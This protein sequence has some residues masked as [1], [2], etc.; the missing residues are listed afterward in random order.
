MAGMASTAPVIETGVD[1]LIEL[2]ERKKDLSLQE[3]ANLLGV[4]KVVVEEWVSFLEEEGLISVDYKLG[5]TK[6][7]LKEL[8]PQDVQ[9]KGKEFVSQKEGFLRKLE[10]T[11]S[12]IEK[13]HDWLQK[14]KKEFTDLAQE[15]HKEVSSIEGELGTLEK[16]ESL[17]ADLD[18]EIVLQ[19]QA[20]KEEIRRINRELETK[21]KVYE[22]IIKNLERKEVSLDEEKAGAV[23]LLK[24]EERL[25]AELDRITSWIHDIRDKIGKEQ[26]SVHDAQK[27]MD[28]LKGYADG[29]KKEIVSKEDAITQLIGK[30][31]QQE[32]QI[33]ALQKGI[34]AKFL[35][36]RK[37][38][39][40]S[41]KFVGALSE[42]FTSAFKKKKE[43][44]DL[45]STMEK[46]ISSIREEFE[47]LIKKAKIFQFSGG[48]KDID[49]HTRE[50]EKKYKEIERRRQMFEA[51]ALK[52][53]GLLKDV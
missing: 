13:E 48:G 51:E 43:V 29:I 52:L 44:L 17:K 32:M 47:A 46:D 27:H 45:F 21:R 3:A 49:K 2:I 36:E 12:T 39:D 30:S 16:F 11:L 26:D 50:I 42:R 22:D 8:S 53:T 1:K 35:K 6:L 14:I 20:Y 38:I 4:P 5:K 9:R 33:A 31:Q 23:S 34:L 28:E 40:E 7:Q 19:E 10:S 15:V 41:T 24:E 18:K 37:K 25:S